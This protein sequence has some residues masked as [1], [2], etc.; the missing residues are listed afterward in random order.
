MSNEVSGEPACADPESFVRGCSTL[1]TPGL[2]GIG[3]VFFC[4]QILF[5]RK[6]RFRQVLT[7]IH[8]NNVCSIKLE[9]KVISLHQ[10]E[11]VK[12]LSFLLNK[13]AVHNC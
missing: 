8:G 6:S 13:Y 4:D 2:H 9:T 1:T 10:I 5:Y 3:G 11:V 7:Q 12:I